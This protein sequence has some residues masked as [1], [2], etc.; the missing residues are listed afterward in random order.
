MGMRMTYVEGGGG[1]GEDVVAVVRCSIIVVTFHKLLQ[2]SSRL[3]VFSVGNY[4]NVRARVVVER[5]L[6]SPFSECKTY[7]ESK[8]KNE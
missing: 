1:G 6:L 3:R 4:E 7:R 5:H 8:K 2:E